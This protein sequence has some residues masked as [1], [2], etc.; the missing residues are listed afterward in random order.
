[1]RK[2]SFLALQLSSTWPGTEVEFLPQGDYIYLGQK[3]NFCPELWSVR[4]LPTEDFLV[5]SLPWLLLPTGLEAEALTES[6]GRHDESFGFRH[7]GVIG[8]YDLCDM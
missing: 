8:Q 7:C 5:L 4:L 1:M 3:G 2:T 6:I